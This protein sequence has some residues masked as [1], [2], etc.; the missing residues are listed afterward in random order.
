M[1]LKHKLKQIKDKLILSGT[2]NNSKRHRYTFEKNEKFKFAFPEFMAKLK[3]KEKEVEKIKEM[4]TFSSRDYLDKN[5]DIIVDLRISSIQ[6]VCWYF[7]NSKYEVDVFFGLKKIIVLVR[8]KRKQNR[9]NLL[10]NLQEITEWISEEEMAGIHLIHGAES[11]NGWQRPEDTSN[12]VLYLSRRTKMSLRL[13]KSRLEEAAKLTGQILEIDEYKIVVGES[14]I[15]PLST[16]S[17]IFS[18]Y[19]SSSD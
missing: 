18:R 11:G 13:P 8:I 16:S 14:T 4:F 17:T 5:E 2:S 1:T 10:N 3:F 6:D 7:K 19:V 9:E 15:K 12:E